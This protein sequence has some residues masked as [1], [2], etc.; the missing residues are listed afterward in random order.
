MSGSKRGGAIDMGIDI[1]I[2]LGMLHP[3]AFDA[4]A[5]AADRSGFESIWLPE[6]LVFPVEMGGSPFPGDDHPPVP[7]ETPLFDVFAYLSYLAAR[8]GQVR[9][10]TWV[11]LLGLRHP[12]VAAR[13]VS[14][15]DQVSK[16]RAIVGVGAGWLRQEWEAAGLDP[17]T[18]GRRLDEHLAVCRRLWTEDVIEHHGRFVDFAPVRF[19]PKPIQRPHPPVLAGGESEAA[20][21]R[22]VESCEG[23]IGVTHTPESAARRVAELRVRLEA[24]GRDPAEFEFVA[25]GSV[26]GPADIEAYARAGLTRV[27]VSP[28]RRS[29]EAADGIA[30]FADTLAAAGVPLRRDA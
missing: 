11:Y 14:T 12:F 13:A 25:G 10:G 21:D 17:R 9:L 1:G 26:T 4:A 24:A 23:W 7:A 22:A 29:R 2:G 18:R 20:L 8:T 6:H 28:W 15:L 30:A 3:S 27:I 16:G 5:Q 19:E